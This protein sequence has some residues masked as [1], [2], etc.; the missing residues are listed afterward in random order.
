MKG[1]IRILAML[2]WLI[3]AGAAASCLILFQS[4]Q[5]A[6]AREQRLRQST[7]GLENRTS[8]TRISNK[9]LVLITGDSRAAQLGEAP[10]GDFAVVNRG[11]PGQTTIE[12]LA[13]I[14]RDMAVSRPDHVIVIAGVNDLKQGE[15]SSEE[16][17]A[18]VRSFEEML[19]IGDAMGIPVTVCPI[20]GASSK[21]TL[22]GLALPSNLER[23]VRDANQ[24][25][26]A[27][28]G[29][30]GAD[31]ANADPLLDEKGLVRESLS[32]DAL[33]L[34]AAGQEVLRKLLLESIDS[35]DGSDSD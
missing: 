33:H 32:S 10:L 6:L 7:A 30:R 8:H 18:I 22:R 25:L 2:G 21:P 35:N 29:E 12:V 31:I 13:R 26:R 19:L 9:P 20:W 16:M 11:V 14:G 4:L 1:R 23:D 34:N 3:A 27:V 15:L 5:E 28:A 24:L 17:A